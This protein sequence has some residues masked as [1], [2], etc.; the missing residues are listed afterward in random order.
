MTIILTLRADFEDERD[1]KIGLLQDRINANDH[2]LRGFAE[3]FNARL[4]SIIESKAAEV[5]HPTFPNGIGNFAVECYKE[6]MENFSTSSSAN[7]TPGTNDSPLPNSE[8]HLKRRRP[9]PN[10]LHWQSSIPQRLIIVK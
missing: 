1:I 2:C 4:E 10:G 7:D 3:Y 6:L 5:I 9:P 8:Q